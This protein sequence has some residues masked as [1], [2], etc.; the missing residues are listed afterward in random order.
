MC[1]ITA[2]VGTDAALEE[3]L[4]S[5]SNLEYRG[6]D[7]AGVALLD[8]D[9]LTVRKC[10]GETDDLRE[11]V[12]RNRP[13]GAIGLGH[14][15]WS[16]HGP[17][18]D[19]NAHP[20][21]GCGDRVAVVHNG[22]I[23]NYESLRTELRARGHE[24]SS[25][26]DTEVVPHLLEERLEAGHAP[27]DAFREVIDALEGSYAIAMAVAGDDVV[28]ATRNGSPL[29]VGIGDEANYVASDIPAFLEFTDSV[30]Y[31][32]D[33]DVAVVGDDEIRVTDADGD[34]VVRERQT[35]EWAAGDAEKSGYNHYMLK[36]INEQ[37]V[38]LR[39]ATEGRTDPADGEV[40]L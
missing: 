4:T 18:S 10:E 28:Y 9:R 24:F 7:S 14:T 21:T 38:A 40:V 23:E 6:Y 34:P 8:E 39:Q 13:S 12:T 22:I 26:T 17:P 19:A 27:E 30:V 32:E 25:E 16:T 15:R 3:L 11:A 20:H 35:V 31:L 37:P 29:V 5:L 36:E 33:D 1:G 2:R